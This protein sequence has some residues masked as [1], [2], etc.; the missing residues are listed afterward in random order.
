MPV[1]RRPALLL[2]GIAAIGVGLQ[3]AAQSRLAAEFSTARGLSQWETDGGTWTMRED[4]LALVEAGVPSG[5]IRR[6]GAMS[7]FRSAPVASFSADI[8]LRSTAPADLAVRDVL[9]I[10]GY[11][12]ATEFYYVHL[13]ARTDAVHNGIFLV[14]HADRRRLDQPTSRARLADQAWHHVRLERD[15][16]TGAIDVYFDG[17]PTPL[18]SAADRTIPAGRVGVGSFDETAEFRRFEINSR[19]SP[20]RP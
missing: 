15:A 8:E 14:H 20:S 7:I 18:L 12:S 3:P 16:T 10:F 1:R 4:V 2:V 6:P 13:S 5:P 19:P 9:L 17:D 11:R